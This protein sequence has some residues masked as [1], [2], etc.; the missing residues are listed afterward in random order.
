MDIAK[1]VSISSSSKFGGK[2]GWKSFNNLPDFI[3]RQNKIINEGDIYSFVDKEKI[4]LI[5]ILVKRENGKL[6]I[7][8]IPSYS[9]K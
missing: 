5:K 9:P 6:S 7:K 8:E 4:K 3:K 2:I 1:Q